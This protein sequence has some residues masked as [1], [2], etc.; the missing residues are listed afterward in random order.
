M[1]LTSRRK[2]S[3]TRSESAAALTLPFLRST[4]VRVVSNCSM[5]GSQASV[6]G[7]SWMSWIRSGGKTMDSTR[8]RRG[9]SMTWA[10]GKHRS[11]SCETQAGPV[12]VP[13]RRPPPLRSMALL[14]SCRS[15]SS[16]ETEAR[17]VWKLD[18]KEERLLRRSVELCREMGRDGSAPACRQ[19]VTGAYLDLMVEFDIVTLALFD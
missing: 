4:S 9:F 3:P 1:G 14:L 12:K 17:S 8:L 2:L 5:T 19:S 15:F 11:A 13:T 6:T 16:T 7:E 18:R 10:D